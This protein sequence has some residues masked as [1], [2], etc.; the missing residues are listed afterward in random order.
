MSI[1]PKIHW[2]LAGLLVTA[3]PI[4]SIAKDTTSSKGEVP[5]LIEQLGSDSY[6]TRTKAYERLQRMGLEAFDQLHAAQFHADNEIAMSAR[7]LVSS[8]LVSWS[9]ESDPPEVREV[10]MEYGAQPDAERE[11]RIDMLAASPDRKGLAALTRLTRFETS[12]RLSRHAALALMQQ[13]MSDD[14]ETRRRNAEIIDDVLSD[15]QRQGAQWLRAYAKD[16]GSGQ[17]SKDLWR[18]LIAD[19]REQIDSVASGEA[20]RPSV[21]ELVRVCATRASQAGLN[22][23]ALKLASENMDLIA[24]TTRDLM[25]ATSWAIDNNLHPFVL[26]MRDQHT[27][28][29]DRQPI[30]LYGAAEARHTAGDP[31]GADDLAEQ[32][33]QIRPLPRTDADKA[34]M[35]P[36][37]I[38]EAAQAHREIGKTL[39]E[40]G[41]FKWAEREYKQI[42]DSMDI[43]AR[44][45]ANARSDLAMMLGELQR[46]DD[47]VEVL[48]PLVER[49]ENDAKLKQQMNLMMMATTQVRSNL[50]YHRALS[51]LEKGETETAKPLLANAYRIYP[52]NVDIL[53][54]MYRVESDQEWNQSVRSMLTQAIRRAESNVQRAKLGLRQFGPGNDAVLAQ[55]YNQY[56]W[57]VSNTEGDYQKALDYSLKSLELEMDFAKLDTCARC[58]FAAGDFESAVLTQRRAVKLMPHS[59]ALLRQLKEF[60]ERRDQERKDNSP[61]DK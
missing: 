4:L 32:A 59:P 57:L 29:F 26:T 3:L 19:Q 1:R 16:M 49:M 18:A 22:D 52:R 46:H 15:N 13:K 17:Y 39:E 20:T 28:M 25:D 2:L 35:Q 14:E 42:I 23:E 6:T 41:L 8:L 43:N 61:D 53:I 11:S 21:L 44:T 48:E 24:P 47:V 45:S 34:Q 10:L 30:L 60:E 37:E 40:R 58:Y 36:K 33:S 51:L 27:P 5:Q 12:L 9:K 54:S 56:A 7:F 50:D 31:T 38:E 55:E